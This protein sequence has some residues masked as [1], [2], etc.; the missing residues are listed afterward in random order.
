[1]RAWVVGM[2]WEGA[3]R[4]AGAAQP[5]AGAARDAV[6]RLALALVRQD[7]QAPHVLL[8]LGHPALHNPPRLELGCTKMRQLHLQYGYIVR[9]C[10]H[11]PNDV[12]LKVQPY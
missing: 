10:M 1:M 9:Q 7:V 5:G 2:T 12:T 4:G 11:N 3:V 6:Q 8:Q